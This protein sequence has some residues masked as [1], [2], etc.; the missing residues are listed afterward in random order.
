MIYLKSPQEIQIM[1]EGGQKLAEIKDKLREMIKPGITPYEID[2]EAESL[3]KGAGGEP[4]FKMVKNYQ[5]TTCININSGVVHGVP[6][7]HPLQSGDVVSV[8]VGMFY[9]GYHTDT[10]FTVPVGKVARDIQ[11]FLKVGQE[12]LNAAIRQAKVSSKLSYISR[13]MQ[14]VIEKNGYAPIKALTGHG[15]GKNLH[16]DPTIPCFWPDSLGTGDDL[17]AG[18]VLAIEAIYAQGSSDVVLSEDKWTIATKDGKI[19]GLFEET[20]A[21]R[22]KSPLVLTV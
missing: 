12:A 13:A 14:E 7:K 2:K 5:W 20:V 11:H 16:E 15:I 22:D 19:A 9:K 8:D 3:V 10:S 6:T 21:V 17:A 18:M 1:Q 4:S